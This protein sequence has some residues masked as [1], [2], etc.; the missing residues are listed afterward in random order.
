[1]IVAFQSRTG[2]AAAEVKLPGG[3]W[4]CMTTTPER[5]RLMLTL[6]YRKQH[7]TVCHSGTG[8]QIRH[9]KKPD[10]FSAKSPFS[11]S[12]SVTFFFSYFAFWCNPAA[13]TQASENIYL[14]L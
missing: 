3:W 10:E 14:N 6:R 13:D 7:S 12:I 9:Q 8:G 2:E 1:M 4:L 5:A 11:S